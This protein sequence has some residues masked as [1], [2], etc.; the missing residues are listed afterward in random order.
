MLQVVTS[1]LTV[2]II[3]VAAANAAAL[4]C[5]QLADVAADRHRESLKQKNNAVAPPGEDRCGDYSSRFFA[6]VKARR[7]VST[8]DDG[9]D[10]RRDLDVLDAQIDTLNN[11]IAAQCRGS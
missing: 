11:L 10:H 1:F 5:G 7:A 8:C 3:T 9:L 4:D 2:L 6:V